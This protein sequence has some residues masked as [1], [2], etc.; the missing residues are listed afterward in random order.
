MKGVVVLD[1]IEKVKTQKD[2]EQKQLPD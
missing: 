2:E 1:A